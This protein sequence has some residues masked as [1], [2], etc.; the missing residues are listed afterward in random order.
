MTS[1]PVFPC[2]MAVVSAAMMAVASPAVAERIKT[3][4]N[5]EFPMETEALVAATAALFDQVQANG[6]AEEKPATGIRLPQLARRVAARSEDASA[7]L[8]LHGALNHLTGYRINWYP[9]DRFL[10]SVDFMGTW[11]GNRNLVCGYVLWDL[12][13]P[14]TPVLDDVNATYVDLADLQGAAPS[15][16]HETLLEAN[17]AF[18]AID[19]NFAFFEVAG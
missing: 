8:S 2:A 18:G 13:D 12:S 14:A 19:A 10:G 1:L 9:T 4:P 16:V 5:L 15:E 3:A 11:N 7:S 6:K 17:C